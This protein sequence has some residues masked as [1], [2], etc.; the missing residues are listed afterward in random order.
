[1][2]L[3]FG[4]LWSGWRLGRLVAAKPPSDHE[5][6]DTTLWG[7]S[8]G[9]RIGLGGAI[10]GGIGR[11][12]ASVG[13]LHARIGAPSEAT[14][15]TSNHQSTARK[16]VD[17]HLAAIRWL[18]APTIGRPSGLCCSHENNRGWRKQFLHPAFF[19]GR[20]WNICLTAETI[21]A[22]SAAP[23]LCSFVVG[24][25][26][27]AKIVRVLRLIMNKKTKTMF[28]MQPGG[29]GSGMAMFSAYEFE[30]HSKAEIDRTLS[31]DLK[32][33]AARQAVNN[34]SWTESVVRFPETIRRSIWQP[35]ARRVQK[36]SS[37]A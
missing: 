25:E 18:I 10:V 12:F 8:A 15:E 17:G 6:S 13:Q 27:L 33:I 31:S 26:D 35:L 14:P 19:G 32:P 21:L 1:M 23:V 22:G 28:V 37:A 29:F 20:F 24:Q 9:R 36:L 5:R 2:A 16:L 7:R 30:D 11:S 3:F 34:R 4:T